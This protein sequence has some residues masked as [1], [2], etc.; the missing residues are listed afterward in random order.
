MR[1]PLLLCGLLLAVP[2]SAQPNWMMGR[3]YGYG[4]PQDKTS[5][6]LETVLPGG[7]LHVHHRT[8][9]QGKAFDENQEG[10][11]SIKGDVITLRIE[12]V[13]GVAV[14]PARIDVYRVL[15]HD[16]ARQTYRYEATGFVYHS[17]KVDARFQLP[18]CDLAS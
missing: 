16:A 18:P 17:R 11:W 3:W 13:D 14:I 1:L 2:A 15:S 12:K 5:M 6:W 4:Q 9:V 8:C 7:K 10:S